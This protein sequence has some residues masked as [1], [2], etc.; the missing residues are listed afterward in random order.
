VSGAAPSHAITENPQVRPIVS[1]IQRIG[2]IQRSRDYE[3]VTL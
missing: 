3:A 2:A 1:C